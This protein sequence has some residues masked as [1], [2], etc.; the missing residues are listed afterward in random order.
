MNKERLLPLLVLG[1]ALSIG[2]VAAGERIVEDEKKIELLQNHIQ[3]QDKEIG[4]LW[5]SACY[6]Q[7]G[8][9]VVLAGGT[10]ITPDSKGLETCKTDVDQILTPIFEEWKTQ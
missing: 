1:T 7:A 9:D 6:G 10:D 2:A 3:N 4:K 5:I 8:A